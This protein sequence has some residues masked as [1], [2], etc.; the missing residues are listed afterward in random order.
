LRTFAYQNRA[1]A[2]QAN[3]RLENDAAFYDDVRRE[4]SK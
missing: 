4:F 3:I 2:K 1:A